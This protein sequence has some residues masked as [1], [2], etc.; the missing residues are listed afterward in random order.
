MNLS[1]SSPA[2]PGAPV[3]VHKAQQTP[4]IICPPE[5]PAARWQPFVCALALY[6]MANGKRRDGRFG[7]L[8]GGVSQRRTR[9]T[10]VGA[11]QQLRDGSIYLH[12]WSTRTHAHA[13][14]ATVADTPQVL[15]HCGG[16]FERARWKEQLS[17]WLTATLWRLL[18]I[19]AFVYVGRSAQPPW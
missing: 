11:T 4:S 14:L 1:L 2:S 6:Q 7:G 18:F 5:Y 17:K 10:A 16:V 9:Q 3:M 15:R 8:V 13:V 12:D 19:I